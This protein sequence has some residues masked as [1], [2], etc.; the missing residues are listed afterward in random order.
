MTFFLLYVCICLSMKFILVMLKVQFNCTRKVVILTQLF[1]E[2][3]SNQQTLCMLSLFSPGVLII[4]YWRYFKKIHDVE[5]FK[6]VKNNN[7]VLDTTTTKN[8]SCLFISKLFL[9]TMYISI[10]GKKTV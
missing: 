2:T 5:S 1:T 8:V 6:D 4:G 10:S 3:T 7:I 9:R